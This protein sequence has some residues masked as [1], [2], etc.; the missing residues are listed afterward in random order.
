MKLRRG[1][2]V[3]PSSPEIGETEGYKNMEALRNSSR[4]GFEI[5]I[6]S[7]LPFSSSPKFDFEEGYLC[8]SFLGTI[9]I[10]VE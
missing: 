9:E 7:W 4:F 3:L 5:K 10:Q 1:G 6:G 8:T 2:G